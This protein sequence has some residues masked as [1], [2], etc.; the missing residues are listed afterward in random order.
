[1]NSIGRTHELLGLCWNATAGRN[2]ET[3]NS[4]QR[5]FHENRSNGKLIRDAALCTTSKGTYNWNPLHVLLQSHPPANVIEILVQQAAET[6]R[7]QDTEGLL[8]LHHACWNGASPEIIS[9]L[10]R[11][12]PESV[13]VADKMG[14]L[15]IHCA[16]YRGSS[17]Q[18]LTLLIEAFPRSV[19]MKDNFGWLPLHWACYR[20]A[21]LDILNLLIQSFPGSIDV[22]VN[23]KRPSV[24]LRESAQ[25]D[26]TSV[27]G[28]SLLHMAIASS[29]SA[30][31]TSYS[32][33]RPVEIPL[34]GF[35]Y[36]IR[37]QCPNFS[38]SSPYSYCLV[39]IPR[40]F[41]SQIT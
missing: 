21:S 8:P 2:E 25:H 36:T 29:Y 41:Q 23:N 12:Y 33:W 40:V 37:P 34:E 38:L 26:N 16:C 9:L 11:A 14:T 17:L 3:L 13:Q 24:Y 5:W 18:V 22:E 15:P 20:G 35:H 28:K 6:V 39:L 10:V 27:A 19:T 7:M 31:L 1:M 32:P 30:H 4:L